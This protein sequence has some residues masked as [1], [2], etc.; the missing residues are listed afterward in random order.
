MHHC[1]TT[2]S[3]WPVDSLTH[4]AQ[5]PLEPSTEAGHETLSICLRHGQGDRLRN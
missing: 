5:P 1:P 3:G 2:G 4:L